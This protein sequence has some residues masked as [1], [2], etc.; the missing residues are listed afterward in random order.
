L[1]FSLPAPPS[2][3]FTHTFPSWWRTASSA[4]VRGARGIW[5]SRARASEDKGG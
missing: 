2:L 1:Y 3:S 5:K 4:T